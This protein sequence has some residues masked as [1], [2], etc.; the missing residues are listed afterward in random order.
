MDIATKLR[1]LGSSIDAAL[2]DGSDP[3]EVINRVKSFLKKLEHSNPEES[4]IPYGLQSVVQSEISSISVD[5]DRRLSGEHLHYALPSGLGLEK[6]VPG[7]VPRDKM[8][9]LFGETGT[10]KTAVKQ[11]MCDAMI[12]AGYHVLDF[13]IEDSKELTAQ[14]F[15]ARHTGIPYNRLAAR[16]ISRQEKE[17]LEAVKED[18]LTRYL[19]EDRGPF[20]LD[21]VMKKVAEARKEYPVAAVFLDYIQIMDMD[22]SVLQKE[23]QQLYNICKIAQR[24]A[25]Q[26][27]MAWV[28]VSQ[29][30]RNI[31]ARDD[32]RP[33][34]SD[35]YG[36]SAMQHACKLAIA[37]YLPAKYEPTP[38]KLSF[39]HKFYHQHPDGKIL[40]KGAM[41]L[42]VRKAFGEKD[43]FLPLI[44]D[45]ATGKLLDIKP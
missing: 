24:A 10:L 19:I 18:A 26:D 2:D 17:Q 28:L 12:K 36:S 15:L 4:S 16:E 29:V 20:T 5:F 35:M 22:S 39:W 9:M 44:F 38:G 34:L 21:G 32:K 27:N 23:Y 25:K 3:S 41:E 11:V 45:P 42:W 37:T 14:R 6:I 40:Y 43:V 13:S 31:E 7:G 33:R 30:N 8:T 1:T